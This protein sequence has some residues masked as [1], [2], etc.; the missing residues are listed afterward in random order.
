MGKLDDIFQSFDEPENKNKGSLDDVFES[1]NT[2]Q[3]ASE[4]AAER[5]RKSIKHK[6]SG[7]LNEIVR[8]IPS[9][10]ADV[11]LTAGKALYGIDEV[12]GNKGSYSQY[13]DYLKKRNEGLQKDSTPGF[14][15]GRIGGQVA[16]TAPFVPARAL[17]AADT[18][19]PISREAI[20]G[21]VSGG[22]FG[23]LTSA[24]N[25]KS[26]PENALEGAVTGG[27]VGPV[28]STVINAGKSAA[29]RAKL[30]ADTALASKAGNLDHN[31]VKAILETFEEAGLT[32]AQVDAELKRLGP[33]ATLADIDP[34]FLAEAEG[35]AKS[36]GSPTS[37]I[38]K[39]F[40]ARA[41]TANYDTTHIINKHLG[42]NV[43][44]EA[45]KER[46]I[47]DAQ[48]ATKKDY[49][50]AHTAAGLDVKPVIDAIDAKLKTA[51]GPKAGDL[52]EIKSYF[53]KTVKDHKGN[54]IQ[55]LKDDLESL[56]EIR[57]QLDTRINN[58]NPTTS[59]DKN[60]LNAVKDVR[61]HLDTELKTIPEMA[62]ADAKY[63]EKM[64]VLKGVDIGQ[65][66]FD[67]KINY[68]QFAKEF[69]GA[70]AEKQNVIR[71]G[72]KAHIY[73]VLERATKGELTEAQKLFGKNTAN[74][75]KFK[76]AYGQNA[77]EV[78]DALEKEAKFNATEKTIEG[79]A[80][81]GQIQAVQQKYGIRPKPTGAGSDIVHGMMADA[82][83]TGS[84]IFT[85]VQTAKRGYAAAT[86]RWA[87]RGIQEKVSGAADILSRS[88]IARDNAMDTLSR[89]HAVRNRIPVQGTA[90][91]IIGRTT[92][93]LLMP[94]PTAISENTTGRNEK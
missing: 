84:P 51:V 52:Q 42:G 90:R 15:V 11:G 54:P 69:N 22:I 67:R 30:W 39:R 68:G 78:L 2:P 82:L 61:A 57:T 76:L 45:L 4:A 20:K 65:K 46:I 7:T 83:S 43:D 21:A 77:D 1:F 26:V 85:A 59:Y 29:T 86:N 89:V 23:G 49:D 93:R 63:A 56:H 64:K 53:Y 17:K 28:A 38:K 10:I 80:R 27:V 31:A 66:I 9:G 32:P 73:D 60:S 58:K 18:L 24:S 5:T 16:A 92:N 72:I 71:E 47:E 3:S 88:G 75:E 91:T 36:G 33:K 6:D 41:D 81:T 70:S 55:V 8:G 40:E 87:T 25:D 94:L 74:R 35:L 34:A 50:I 79:G 19:L 48:K 13:T 14:E 44:I 37:I 62:S 12:L